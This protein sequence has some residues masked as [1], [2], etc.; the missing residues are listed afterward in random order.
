[1]GP[2]APQPRSSF[3]EWNYRAELFAFGKRLQEEFQLPLLQTAFTQQSYITQEEQKQRDLGIDEIDL[4]ME[5]NQKLAEQGLYIIQQYVAAFLQYNLPKVP[6]EGQQAIAGYL[7]SQETLAYIAKNL[8]MSDLILCA[9]YPASEESLAQSFKAVV[10]ALHE[11]TGMERAFNFVRDFVC[12]QLNQK[13]LLELWEI[14]EPQKML[15]QICVQEKLGEP[16]PRLLGD[17]GKN[18]VL[19]AFQVGMYSNKKLI[20]KGI[21]MLLLHFI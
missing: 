19:A 4:K 18:T 11:S 20:G 21:N 15:Q 1:M 9:E 8:G 5:N 14:K 13:D 7:S 3:V 10:G 17:C 6:A 16:E 2:Q 12:T